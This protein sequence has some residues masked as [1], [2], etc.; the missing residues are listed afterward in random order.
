MEIKKIAWHRN[1]VSGLDFHVA[2]VESEGH[3]MVVVRFPGIDDA[4]GSVVCAALDI[5]RLNDNCIEFTQN[6]WRGDRFAPIIDSAI[7]SESD[8]RPTRK[9]AYKLPHDF[10]AEKKTVPP[11]KCETCRQVWNDFDQSEANTGTQD[12]LESEG[13]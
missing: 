3:R 4:V 6:S 11:C 12:H 9:V 5:D 2:I 13:R 8:P 10:D 7:A 1:G